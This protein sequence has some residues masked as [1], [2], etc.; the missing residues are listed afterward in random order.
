LDIQKV[1][2]SRNKNWSELLFNDYNMFYD[3]RFISYN[4]VFNKNIQWH[5]LLF[6]GKEKN[7]VTAILNGCERI[8]EGKKYYISCDGV[9][10]GG[11]LWRDRLNVVDYM[12][13]IN[14]FKDYLRENA[15]DAC[16]IRNQPFLYEKHPNEEYE[17]SLINQGFSISSHSITNIISLNEFEFEKL[18]NP[19]KRAIQK[20]E[21]KI[22]IKT[23]EENVNADSLRAYYDVLFRNRQKKNVKPTHTLEELVYLKQN[24]PE[25][26]IFFSAEIENTIA[27][28]C[29]LF[30]IK[31]DVVLNFY[32]ATDEIYKKERVADF[33]LYKSIEWAKDSN[34]RLYDIGTSNVGNNFLEGLFEFKKKFM[35]N[36]FLRKTFELQITQ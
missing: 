13:T 12:S 7:K 1:D 36:G 2:I 29:I 9:S 6:R 5:H 8:R 30:L 23:I 14:S 22:E 10:F 16:I 17:Y 19:K 25:R 4:D 11:F 27:G 33:L 15:F 18:T 35:A 26:I 34:Y 3:D 32:L 28:V 20:S 31:N 24:L 21:K